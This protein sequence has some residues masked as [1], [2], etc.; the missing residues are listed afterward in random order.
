MFFIH[1]NLWNTG[2]N[3][4]PHLLYTLIHLA[5]IFVLSTFGRIYPIH[6]VQSFLLG[7]L[8]VYIKLSSGEICVA[9]LKAPLRMVRVWTGF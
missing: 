8:Q 1:L 3:L 9:N 7:P 6:S 4:N 2:F 5:G